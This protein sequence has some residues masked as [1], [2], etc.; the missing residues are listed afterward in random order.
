MI[1]HTMDRMGAP[2]TAP[3]MQERPAGDSARVDRGR[4]AAIDRFI[5]GL[6]DA[7][8]DTVTGAS[9]S[10]ARRRILQHLELYGPQPMAGLPHEWPV[11]AQHLPHLVRELEQDGLVERVPGGTGATLYRLTRDG[12]AGLAATRSTQLG[13]IATLLRAA[14]ELD[15]ETALATYDRLRSALGSRS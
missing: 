4:N 12:V 7:T 10:A 8:E 15:D 9:Y 3:G 6:L 13:L 11:T 1:M 5:A 2:G 14:A